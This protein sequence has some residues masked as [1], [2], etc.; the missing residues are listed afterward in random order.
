[1]QL[2]SSR[3]RPIF[4]KRMRINSVPV[5][6]L[7][8]KRPK[9]SGKRDE[10]RVFCYVGAWT[11]PECEACIRIDCIRH[12]RVTFDRIQRHESSPSPQCPRD[13]GIVQV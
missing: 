4:D 12:L 7:D 10:E 3:Y 9:K 6:W 13:R 1:M 5:D 8:V 2:Q 11:D